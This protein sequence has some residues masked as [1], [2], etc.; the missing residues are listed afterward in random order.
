M[1]EIGCGRGDL[2][3]ALRPARGVG[4]DV[5][6]GMLAAARRRHPELTFVNDAGEDLRLDETSNYIILAD[7]VPT[8]SR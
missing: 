6:R 8:C 2:L 5:S 3:A 7:L 1:L 4:V